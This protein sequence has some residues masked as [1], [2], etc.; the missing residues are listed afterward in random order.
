MLAVSIKYNPLLVKQCYA[1]ASI[2]FWLEHLSDQTG[3]CT[4]QRNPK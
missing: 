2:V 1:V 3:I 4:G